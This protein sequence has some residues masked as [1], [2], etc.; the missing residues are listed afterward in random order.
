MN[1][2]VAQ[3]PARRMRL[4]GGALAAFLTLAH[5]ATDAFTSMFTALLPTIQVRFGLSETGLALLVAT[6][7][8]SASITQPMMGALADRIG[9]RL[10]V[11]LGV[12]LSSALISLVGVVP[13]VWLLVSLLLVGG[14][15]SAAFHPAGTSI[16]RAAITGNAGL[17]VSLFSAGGTLGIA[18]GPVIV[19]AIVATS[20][21]EAT[22]WLL[23]PGLALGLLTYLIV[24]PQ[25]RCLPGSCPKLVD[26]RLF[27]GPVGLLALAG[28][29]ASIA[30]I[31][32]MS[33]IPLW[34][35]ANRGLARDD[36]LIGWTLA[37]FSLAAAMGGIVAGA[38]SA[39]INR[40]LLV[41]GSML[42]APLPLLAI[43][44]LNPGT[45]GFFLVVVLAGGLMNAGMPLLLVSAQDLAPHAVGTASGMLM[46]FSTGT[47]GVLY[48][49]VG[50][51]QESI[52]LSSAMGL[53]YLALIPGALVAFTVLSRYRLALEGTG[54]MA[55]ASPPCV[56]LATM[57]VP[58]A[59][60]ATT[61]APCACSATLGV[62]CGCT[63]ARDH[64]DNASV[65]A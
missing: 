41:V 21:L 31:T 14:L 45:V 38:L 23:L 3:V 17:A 24:P 44:Q 5:L 40:R 16:A 33:A 11:A 52:G 4:A 53:S 30:L 12:G 29:L 20:G 10:V 26:A 8:F 27:A 51:L 54:R 65:A 42:L 9:R 19:L 49:G 61:M 34:L 63:E 62:S 1:P 18:L 37:A 22:R 50:R 39:H 46:G 15:G 6:L 13:D 64:H 25:G 56:C 55:L 48:V 36:A 47:A 43:F 59:C 58:C 2:T 35:V 28:V 60:A 57:A 7:S 32:F